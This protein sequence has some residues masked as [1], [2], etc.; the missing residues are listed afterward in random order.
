M[1][2]VPG[3]R[4]VRV[5]WSVGLVLICFTAGCAS[6]TPSR[7]AHSANP[8]SSIRQ[9]APPAS[10]TSADG[11]TQSGV[12]EHETTVSHVTKDHIP[13]E[14]LVDGRITAIRADQIQVNIGNP[15]P[16]YLPL[17]P[18]VDKGLEFH[19]GDPIVVAMN[20]HNAVVD[21]HHGKGQSKHRVIKGQLIEPLT[22]GSDKAVVR[23]GDREQSYRIA[24]RARGKL[25]AMPIGADAIFLADETGQL[26]DAQLGSE[27]AVHQSAI[28]NKAARVKGAHEQVRAVYLG[29]ASENGIKVTLPPDKEERILPI[30]P[31]LQKLDRLKDNE[32]VVLLMDDE[33]YVVEIATPDVAPSP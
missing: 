29:T 18:A 16:L 11:S 9:S 1:R 27:E 25:G 6:S 20:D 13:G 3:T 32:A 23:S 4:V 33:G 8:S 21:Y 24:S 19:V 30:R 15:E 17:K 7:S 5:S 28:N 12:I 22:V 2:I 31:P 14:R 26:V 10:I